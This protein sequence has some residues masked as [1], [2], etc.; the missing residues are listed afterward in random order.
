MVVPP[1][2]ITLHS[3]ILQVYKYSTISQPPMFSSK[4]REAA[5]AL[6][7]DGKTFVMPSEDG[8]LHESTWLQ[9]PHNFGW[10]KQHVKRLEPIWIQ[11]TISLCKD[12]KVYIIVYN[13]SEKERITTLLK[14]SLVV[15]MTQ[16]SFFT[17]P[18]NDVWVRDS[19]PIFVFDDE[20]RLAVTD[21]EFNGWGKKSKFDKCNR[22]P[23]EVASQLGIPVY[24]IPMVNE[25][26]S[27]EIDGRGTLMAKRSSILNKNRNPGWNQQDVEQYFGKYLGVVNF[28][29]LDGKKGGDITDDHIDGTARFANGDTIVTFRREDHQDPSEYDVLA[30]AKDAHGE[31]YRLVHLPLTTKTIEKVRDHGIYTNFYVGNGVVLM[32]TYNDPNDDVAKHIFANLY[33]QRQI[34]GIDAVE[35]YKDGGLLHCVTQQQPAIN[36]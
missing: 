1:S 29:W 28:I 24:S 3:T 10:D 25:G 18:T 33:P 12:E 22:I 5:P 21:W 13:E 19:G 6:P 34:V 30:N 9:W 4:K 17:W 8:V 7:D 20:R 27:I 14:N 26:G 23:R 35:L 15:D 2:F 32:P 31:P 16:V 36:I 11:M